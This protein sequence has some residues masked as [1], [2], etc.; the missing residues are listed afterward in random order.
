MGPVDQILERFV[1]EAEL[2]AGDVGNEFGAR[3]AARVEKLFPGNVTSK[4]CLV[5]RSKKCRL[6]MIEPPGEFVGR[7]ILEIDDRVFVAIQ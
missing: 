5:C 4:M 7:R 3:L 1:V 6:M 2:A